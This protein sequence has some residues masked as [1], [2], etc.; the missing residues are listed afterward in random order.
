M[1][2]HYIYK[3]TDPRYPQ[4]H[5]G[6]VWYIG[7]TSGKLSSLPDSLTASWLNE[8]GPKRQKLQELLPQNVK[9]NVIVIEKVT[10]ARHAKE[11][12]EHW[13]DHYE[14]LGY[15]LINAQLDDRCVAWDKQRVIEDFQIEVMRLLLEQGSPYSAALKE[16]SEEG[17]EGSALRLYLQAAETPDLSI[18]EIPALF[19]ERDERVKG[20]ERKVMRA[21]D[22]GEIQEPIASAL[23]EAIEEGKQSVAEEGSAID[24]YIMMIA[25]TSAAQSRQ[26]AKG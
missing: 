14:G 25:E 24:R 4:E 11:R 7:R 5:R 8:G 16:L 23:K 26:S 17:R 18:E 2:Y 6:H 22:S 10:S 12:V 3:L 9:P 13:I 1:R 21:I 20:L 15:E 19:Q